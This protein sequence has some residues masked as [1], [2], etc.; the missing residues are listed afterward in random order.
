MKYPAKKPDAREWEDGVAQMKRHA[1]CNIDTIGEKWEDHGVQISF[2]REVSGSTALTTMRRLLKNMLGAKCKEHEVDF[3]FVEGERPSGL[4]GAR[5]VRQVQQKVTTE[6]S[7]PRSSES[8]AASTEIVSTSSRV[9]ASA[10]QAGIPAP[11]VVFGSPWVSAHQGAVSAEQGAML[12][13]LRWKAQQ[14]IAHPQV[15]AW[16]PA[17]N[18]QHDKG[19]FG[20]V[21]FGFHPLLQKDV[22]IKTTG[23]SLNAECKR[24]VE[25]FMELEVLVAVQGHPCIVELLDVVTGPQGDAGLVFRRYGAS[26]ERVLQSAAGVAQIRARSKAVRLPL[27][28]DSYRP[29]AAGVISA[30]AFMA[31]RHIAHLDIKPANLCFDATESHQ[32]L[33][34]CDLGAGCCLKEGCF[35]GWPRDLIIRKNGVEVTSMPYRSPELLFGQA[36]YNVAVD[37]WSLGLVLAEMTELSFFSA[38]SPIQAKCAMRCDVGGTR[39]VI[40]AA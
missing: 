22:A 5:D 19:T 13:H 29:I 36:N 4:G 1:N 30:L 34:L 15:E 23:S 17:P 31:E 16:V 3:D 38:T 14:A 24:C 11:T 21:V 7:G 2:K 39:L 10:G 25:F 27:P 33:V 20:K 37:V 8:A 28:F 6:G 9:A 40:S 35:F 12:Q 26:L 32:K 18:I